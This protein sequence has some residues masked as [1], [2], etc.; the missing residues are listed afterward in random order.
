[1]RER[2][3]AASRV[4]ASFVPA[5]IE[6]RAPFDQLRDV[7]RAFFN[8]QRH[9]FGPAKAVA[10]IDRVLFVEADFVFVAEGHG[11]PALC[12][13]SGRIAKKDLARTRTL[14]ALLSSM[15]A[16]RPATPEP[17]TR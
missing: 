11:N 6:F 9:R 16:R 14:P 4:K 5:A 12:P 7:L 17:T 10:R 15:A 2:L 8:E 13:G 3:C 1:M